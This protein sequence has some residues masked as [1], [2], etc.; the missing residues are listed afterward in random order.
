MHPQ[1]M[2]RAH[3]ITMLERFVEDAERLGARFQPLGDVA[4]ALT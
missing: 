2:G 3:R 1:V 4:A